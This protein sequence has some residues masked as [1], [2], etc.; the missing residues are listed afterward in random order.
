MRRTQSAFVA[1]FNGGRSH[2]VGRNALSHVNDNGLDPDGITILNEGVTMIDS[3]MDFVND[4]F[5][6]RD[7]G[8]CV[9]IMAHQGRPS[10][11]EL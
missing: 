9:T 3:D 1:S 6:R 10:R 4:F 11:K 5:L 7:E 2:G 8:A